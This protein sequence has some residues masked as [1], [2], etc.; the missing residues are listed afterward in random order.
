MIPIISSKDIIVTMCQF[1]P[2]PLNHVPPLIFYYEPMHTFVLDK[3]LFAQVLTIVPHL[4]SSG[5]FGMVY[6]HLLG[7]SIL[8]RP[9]F[10]VFGIIPGYCYSSLWGYP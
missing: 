5:I 1:H 4:S 10:W 2:I 9:I 8:K 6:E 7:C 3:T